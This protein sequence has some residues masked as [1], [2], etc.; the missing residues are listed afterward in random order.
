MPKVS[1]TSLIKDTHNTYGALLR[2]GRSFD[3]PTANSRVTPFAGL[4]FSVCIHC[5]SLTALRDSGLEGSWM[6]ARTE[7]KGTVCITLA[8][9]REWRRWRR[10]RV[11]DDLYRANMGFHLIIDLE[12]LCVHRPCARISV[13]V[14]WV[15]HWASQMMEKMIVKIRIGGVPNEIVCYVFTTIFT[16]GTN[17]WRTGPRRMY[18]TVFEKYFPLYSS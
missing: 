1:H 10:G 18:E 7:P 17:N 16:A 13:I 12:H 11:N 5:R 15:L 8:G 6:K 3:E 9:A 14:G 2:I 4:G